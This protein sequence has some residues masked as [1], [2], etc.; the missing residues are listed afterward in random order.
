MKSRVDG[1]RSI[2]Q[3]W[4][5]LFKVDVRRQACNRRNGLTSCARL[6]SIVQGGINRARLGIN[7]AMLGINCARLGPIVHGWDSIVH[8][9]INRSRL[10]LI[11]ACLRLFF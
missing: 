6:G 1:L 7:C 4:N 5:Q 11:F 8:V 2:V 9:W 3:G 10:G